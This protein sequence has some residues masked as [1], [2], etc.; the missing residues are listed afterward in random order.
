[1]KFWSS[2]DDTSSRVKNEL[3]AINLL[4]VDVEKKRVE[5]CR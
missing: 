3:K 2:C 5:L 4:T 1:M